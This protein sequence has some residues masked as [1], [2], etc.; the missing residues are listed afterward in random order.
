MRYADLSFDTEEDAI[1]NDEVLA[2][3]VSNEESEYLDSY[4]S[5][6]FGS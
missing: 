3:I 2:D 4:C 1:N 5:K 6:R